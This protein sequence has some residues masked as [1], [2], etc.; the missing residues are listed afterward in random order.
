V[1]CPIDDFGSVATALEKRFGAP[2]RSGL[3]WRP[4]NTVAV[5][6]DSAESLL[7]M[8]DALDDNDDV[9]NVTSNFEIPDEMMARLSA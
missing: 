3:V 1:T 4:L 9:R 5:S 7:K 2:E 6:G 8:L